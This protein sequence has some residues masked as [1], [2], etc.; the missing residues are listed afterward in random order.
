[1]FDVGLLE[2]LPGRLELHAG[3]TTE[4]KIISHDVS[5]PLPGS[6]PAAVAYAAVEE[7]YT[8]VYA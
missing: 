3:K 4:A 7:M 6:Q 8:E 1:M 2:A 5:A